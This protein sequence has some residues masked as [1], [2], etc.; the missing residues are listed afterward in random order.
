MKKP[1]G[2]NRDNLPPA[3]ELPLE[4]AKPEPISDVYFA[5][6]YQD[7]VLTKYFGKEAAEKARKRIQGD[8]K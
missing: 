4:L 5:E 6:E 2:K 1:S 3:P 8:G 7:E